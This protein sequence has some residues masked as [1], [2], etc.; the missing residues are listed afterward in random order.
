[1]EL[2][3]VHYLQTNETDSINV[4]SLFLHF[5][6]KPKPDTSGQMH[7]TVYRY[8]ARHRVTWVIYQGNDPA[9]IH[10][11][12]DKAG[13]ITEKYTLIA[14]FK[15]GHFWFYTKRE[16]HDEWQSVVFKIKRYAGI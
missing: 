5:M 11:V 14:K 12:Y 2:D 3:Y 4:D 1:M 6:P 16:D 9:I 13:N 15:N 10:Y 8:D 7:T